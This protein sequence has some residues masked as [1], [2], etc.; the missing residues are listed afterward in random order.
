MDLMA[1]TQP[2]AFAEF[3][4]VM[5]Y[6]TGSYEQQTIEMIQKYHIGAVRFINALE[7]GRNQ[8]ENGGVITKSLILRSVPILFGGDGND[9]VIPQE[10][11]FPFWKFLL[12]CKA[13]YTWRF[14]G[15]PDEVVVPNDLKKNR[16]PRVT[17][18]SKMAKAFSVSDT[19]KAVYAKLLE[20]RGSDSN[21]VEVRVTLSKQYNIEIPLSTLN[22]FASS[23]K[24]VAD[25]V[26]KKE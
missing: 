25:S 20:L 23:L 5:L 14:E 15:D 11:F 2:T 13:E 4:D 24:K 17:L 1:S 22:A 7:R 9:V 12:W 6:G 19:P 8:V 21:W 10:A 3:L 26:L 16:G 18:R